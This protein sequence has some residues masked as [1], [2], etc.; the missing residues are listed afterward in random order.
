V[1]DKVE[2]A[3]FGRGV[4]VATA[5][6]GPKQT[7]EIRLSGVGVKRL[8]VKVAPITKLGA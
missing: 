6:I 2:H 3:D 7:D 5:G 1:G 4:V 8:L